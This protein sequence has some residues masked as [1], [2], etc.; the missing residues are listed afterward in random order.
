MMSED[1]EETGLLIAS[2]KKSIITSSR[3]RCAKCNHLEIENLELKAELLELRKKE[4]SIAEVDE[5]FPIQKIIL[6]FKDGSLLQH[7]CL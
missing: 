3:S 2:R 7:F 4:G 5:K 1:D 6:F